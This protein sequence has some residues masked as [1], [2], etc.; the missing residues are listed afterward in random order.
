LGVPS[1][2]E[3]GPQHRDD[4][5]S[6]SLTSGPLS[7]NEE[8]G[9]KKIPGFLSKPGD[10]MRLRTVLYLPVTLSTPTVNFPTV[11]GWI[12]KVLTLLK[13]IGAPLTASG[14]V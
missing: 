2:K 10:R 9:I 1:T 12:L 14:G 3:L 5:R 11:L 8:G 13:S 6:E 7:V 4:R